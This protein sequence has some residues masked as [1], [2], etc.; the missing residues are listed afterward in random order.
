M[1]LGSLMSNLTMNTTYRPTKASIGHLLS[2]LIL[3]SNCFSIH[4]VMFFIRSRIVSL[5]APRYFPRARIGFLVASRYSLPSTRIASL[6][7]SRYFPCS[8]CLS[9]RLAIFFVCLPRYLF[10][11]CSALPYIMAL[12]SPQLFK[13]VAWVFFYKLDVEIV[14]PMFFH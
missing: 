3:C 1:R 14:Y 9:I 6:Y 12:A 13:I 5:S 7:V 8:N 2:A 10:I 4:L 11:Q